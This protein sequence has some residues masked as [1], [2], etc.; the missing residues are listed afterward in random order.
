[1]ADNTLLNAGTGGDTS[2]SKDRAGV[3]T[4][5]IGLDLNIGGATEVLQTAAL[6]SDITANPTVPGYAVYN[7]LW[8]GGSWDRARINTNN[9][10]S[11]TLTASDAVVAAPLGNGALISGAST[12]GSVIVSELPSAAQ[13]CLS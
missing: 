4:Q 3:K 8:N 1:M 2:R 5:S 13:G 9:A 10:V 11:G 6:L 7:M 12:A